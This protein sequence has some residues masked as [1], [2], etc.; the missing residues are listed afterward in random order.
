MRKELSPSTLI[1]VLSVM[2]FS[3]SVATSLQGWWSSVFYLNENQIL[4][5]F[6][7]TAQVLAAIY[8]LTL[9]GFVF[10]SNELSREE[11]EDETLGEAVGELK[12]RYF[13]LLSFITVLALLTF[14]L[15]NLAMASEALQQSF[16]KVLIINS[17]QSF[18]ATTMLAIAYFIFDVVSPDR[19]KRISRTLQDQ[20][21]PSHGVSRKGGLEDFLRNYNQIEGILRNY[22][23]SSLVSITAY[24]EKMVSRTSNARLA[25]VLFRNQWI[26]EGLFHRLRALITL[27][28]SI[29]HGADPVVSE[30]MVSESAEVLRELSASL[31][32]I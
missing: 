9:T 24:P 21:D 5:I 7:T 11:F 28:N 14:A 20:V 27:R 2:A 22:G 8:G 31:D 3:L 30:A 10:F 18:F 13:I 29:I 1:A 32:V 12:K 4:Y 15:S 6:S 17:G 26:G 25:E 16:V 19:I 23:Y